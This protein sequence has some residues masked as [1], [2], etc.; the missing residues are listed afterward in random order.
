MAPKLAPENEAP[1]IIKDHKYEVHPDTPWGCC[2][3]C[4]LAE[5]A[6]AEAMI[7]YRLPEDLTYRCPNCVQK[8]ID[9]CEHQER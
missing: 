6:H 7:P 2:A 3:L 1:G 5:A 8:N 9:P 4:G